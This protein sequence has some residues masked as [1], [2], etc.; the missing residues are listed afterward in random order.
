MRLTKALGAAGAL[1]LAAVVGGTLIGSTLATDNTTDDDT[2]TDSSTYCDTFMD[3]L[4]AELGTSRDELTAAGQAAANATLDAAVAAGDIDE[5]RAETLRERIAEA[6]G[7]GCAW[8]GHGFARGFENGFE[9]GAVRGFLGF[10]VLDAAADAL[11]LEGSELFNELR[12][13]GSLEAI[14]ESTGTSYDELKATILAAVQS[15][16]DV[17]VEDGLSQERADAV[18]ERLTD[19]LDEGG[20]IGELRP[21]HGHFGPGRGGFG[22]WGNDGGGADTDAEESGA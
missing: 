15:E 10:G 1:I 20:E 4:A 8:F 5:D 21:G 12:D 9:R 2:T 18:L 14:S 17:A 19:W 6:D 11:G 22:P 3:A 16:L 7:T 13:G